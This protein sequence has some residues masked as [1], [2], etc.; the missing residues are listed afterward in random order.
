MDEVMDFVFDVLFLFF[1]GGTL[2]GLV[3]YATCIT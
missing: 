3:V 1:V 2:G